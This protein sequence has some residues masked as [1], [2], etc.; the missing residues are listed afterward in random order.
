MASQLMVPYKILKAVWIK[1]DDRRL[2]DIIVTQCENGRKLNNGFKKEV[3]QDI[4]VKF[5]LSAM[6]ENKSAQQLKTDLQMMKQ[7]WKTFTCLLNSLSFGWN[8]EAGVVTASD[9]VWSDYL[10][11]HIISYQI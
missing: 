3:W 11:V 6:E 9:S 10:T 8:D 5:N 4:I 7:K 2:L 1:Y